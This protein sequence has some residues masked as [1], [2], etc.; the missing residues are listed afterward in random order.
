M[1]KLPVAVALLCMSHFA[2]AS[3]EEKIIKP[4]TAQVVAAVEKIRATVTDANRQLA[5][6]SPQLRF[7]AQMADHAKS[8]KEGYLVPSNR[9]VRVASS[10]SWPDETVTSYILL[11]REDNSV[12]AFMESPVSESGDWGNSYTHY[13]DAQGNTVAFERSSS[14]FI[15]CPSES[16]TETSTYY[17]Q[18]SKL[19]AKDYTLKDNKEKAI[20][21]SKCEFMYRHDYVIRHNWLE[22]KRA[23]G[24][25]QVK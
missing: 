15:G 11:I 20:S 12:A 3:E 23:A 10:D 14:F 2:L 24:I 6:P 4:R 13:F 19:I 7:F 9:V 18:N 17:Y 21:P 8:E 16:A 22:S 5:K 25:G 1:R